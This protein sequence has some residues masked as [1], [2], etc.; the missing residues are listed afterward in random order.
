MRHT[1]NI[2]YAK[3]LNSFGAYPRLNTAIAAAKRNAKATGNSRFIVA[4][5]GEFNV[6]S[7]YDLDTFYLGA[8]V[9]YEIT[10]DGEVLS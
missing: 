3:N 10:P 2:A 8:P 5:D 6:C 9:L 4:E 1:A 7:D